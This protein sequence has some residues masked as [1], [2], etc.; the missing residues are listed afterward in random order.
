MP[1]KCNSRQKVSFLGGYVPNSG[2]N[3]QLLAKTM[4]LNVASFLSDPSRGWCRAEPARDDSIRA[5]QEKSRFA[6]PP[7]LL[8]LWRFSNGGEAEDITLPPLL[9]VL[10]AVEE[11]T[12]ALDR[13]FETEEF[14]SLVFFGSNGGLE[15]IALDY[16]A[17]APPSVVMVDPIAGIESAEKIA[18]DISEF[19]QAIGRPYEN[20]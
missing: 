3:I 14:P 5:F 13:E 20:G 10:D 15:R 19:I 1:L 18:N 4:H 12:D 9:F 7:E 11:A 16:R 6:P 2:D 17:G 8:D